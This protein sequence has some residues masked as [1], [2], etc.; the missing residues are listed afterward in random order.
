MKY[1]VPFLAAIL[2]V[3]GVWLRLAPPGPRTASLRLPATV[4]RPAAEPVRVPGEISAGDSA[5]AVPPR[6]QGPGVRDSGTERKPDPGRPAPSPGWRKMSVQLERTLG[7]TPIQIPLVQELLQARD[8]E[9]KALH[10]G[11]RRA[12]VLNIRDYEWQ[13]GLM[14]RSW[15]QG[16]DALLDASQHEIFTSLV[17]KGFFNEDLAFTVEP[18]MTILE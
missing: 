3:G 4:E 14:K 6:E 5:D 8:K 16:I 18:G 15:Y 11:I 10:E 7:L 2:M 9:I 12:G 13:V 1:A 17:E